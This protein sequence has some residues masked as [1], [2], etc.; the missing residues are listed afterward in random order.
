V[1]L[2]DV[3][4]EGA[5]GYGKPLDGVRVLALEQ[6]QALP[7]ATQLLARLG[8]DVVKIEAPTG[9]SGRGSQPGMTDPD[10]RF[11]G[12]TFLR[13]NLS[14]RSVTVNLKA[15]RGRDLVLALAPHFDVFAEN[16]KSGA[17]DRMGLGYDAVAAVHPSVIYTSLSGFGASG[18]PYT[19][20]PAYASIAESM[21]GIYD[22]VLVGDE[23]PRP[24][25]VGALGDI[26]SGLFATIGILAALRHRDATGE[27]QRVDI[28]MYDATVAMTDIVTNFESLGKHRLNEPRNAILD[29]FRAS[30]GWFV[31]QLVRE[32]QLERISQ[33][34]G[35]PEWPTDPRLATREGWAAHLE[36][37]LRPAIEDWASHMT[38]ME[39]VEKLS[40][41]GI[42]SAPVQTAPE[43]VVDPHLQGRHMLVEMERSDGVERPVLI[44]GNPVKLSKVAEGPESRVPWLGEHTRAILTDELGLDAAT[45]DAL[46]ADGGITDCAHPAPAP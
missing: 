24:N 1:R 14:K 18:S 22:Y 46:V 19:D 26:S 28:A 11:V 5:A 13:N 3:A 4:N 15:D 2:G 12:A 33:L 38:R 17:L 45:I 43:V 31:M 39:A 8:A 36:D 41:A 34:V 40:A 37:M 16:F 6:M 32:H 7:Y 27:G 35:H 10:G 42:A 29:P 25:P 23:M 20:W 44:P 9:E 30:D 21:S